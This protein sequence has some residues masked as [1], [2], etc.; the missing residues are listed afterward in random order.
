ML[1]RSHSN[2]IRGIE[3]KN[4][5]L[6]VFFL[7]LEYK[8]IIPPEAE[9][10]KFYTAGGGQAKMLYR[11]RP[12][13]GKLRWLSGFLRSNSKGNRTKAVLYFKIFAPAAGYASP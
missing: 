12:A 2:E 4:T 9:R 7:I 3:V 13:A 6:A 10:L 8:K 5:P 11:R 1:F